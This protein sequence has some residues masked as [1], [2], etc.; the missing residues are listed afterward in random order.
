M[1]APERVIARILETRPHGAHERI[2]STIIIS[3]ISW[4][5][6]CIWD[7]PD[8]VSC[9]VQVVPDDELGGAA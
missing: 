3:R 8:G 9:G 7:A 4:G 6:V 2:R 1:T 5:W